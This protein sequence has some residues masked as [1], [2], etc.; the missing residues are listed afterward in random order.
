MSNKNKNRFQSSFDNSGDNFDYHM[1]NDSFDRGDASSRNRDSRVSSKHR[2][3][4]RKNKRRNKQ[5]NHE[6]W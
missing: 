6:I 3:M 2:D 4:D 1:H 5:A